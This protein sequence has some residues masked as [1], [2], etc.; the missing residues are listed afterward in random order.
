MLVSLIGKDYTGADA[1]QA[2]GEAFITVN[3]NAVPNDPR[4]PFVTSGLRVGTPAITTRGFGIEETV[5][6]THWMC[7]I[8]D[9]LE[10]G[11]AQQVIAEVKTKVLD[12]CQRYL[13]INNAQ[14]TDIDQER[15]HTSGAFFRPLKGF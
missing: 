11:N 1:D 4:S 12:I 14:S 5:Q 13:F 2:L 15:P 9:A 10:N 8:L 3:K 6:L 7:D